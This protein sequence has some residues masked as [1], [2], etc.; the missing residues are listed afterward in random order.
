MPI[1]KQKLHEA[2]AS[3]RSELQPLQEVDMKKWA[4]RAN[5]PSI[6]KPAEK[7]RSD[8]HLGMP[9]AEKVMHHLWK[10]LPLEGVSFH[11]V[12]TPLAGENT[13]MADF[14]DLAPIFLLVRCVDEDRFDTEV[15]SDKDEMLISLPDQNLEQLM[16]TIKEMHQ[17]GLM[18]SQRPENLEEQRKSFF[19]TKFDAL[20]RIL[21]SPILK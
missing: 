5:L 8:K 13:L 20:R 12:S 17:A 1:D 4:V 15:V 10:E 2:V 18:V 9:L 16:A 14:S 11:V 19:K 6:K 3:V 21:D 7:L